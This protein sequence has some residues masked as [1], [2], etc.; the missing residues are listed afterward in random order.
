MGTAIGPGDA[1][2]SIGRERMPDPLRVGRRSVSASAVFGTSTTSSMAEV[3][4]GV[5]CQD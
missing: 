1:Q 4:I 5:A 3:A 2:P